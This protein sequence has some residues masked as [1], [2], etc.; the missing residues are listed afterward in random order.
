MADGALVD[1]DTLTLCDL[2]T[3]KLVRYSV[4]YGQSCRRS[5]LHTGWA[6][7]RDHRIWLPMFFCI[8]QQIFSVEHISVKSIF[9][10]FKV[11]SPGQVNYSFYFNGLTATINLLPAVLFTCA[12][13]FCDVLPTATS[14]SSRLMCCR[15]QLRRRADYIWTV[16]RRC[17]QF[18]V[19]PLWPGPGRVYRRFH[20]DAELCAVRQMTTFVWSTTGVSCTHTHTR[21]FVYALLC[22]LF[23]CVVLT[24]VQGPVTWA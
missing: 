19:S 14:S 15:V 12:S 1:S 8:F 13:P 2:L 11:E 20:R 24:A 6:K 5:I 23:L 16:V 10:I 3:S 17:R 22:I 18:G 4:Q 7:T 9:V 21:R